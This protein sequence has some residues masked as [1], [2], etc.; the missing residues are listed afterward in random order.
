MAVCAIVRAVFADRSL[1]A[2]SCALAGVTTAQAKPMP[3]RRYNTTHMLKSSL[4]LLA[5]ALGG[6][7]PSES[8]AH[9]GPFVRFSIAGFPVRA[10]DVVSAASR[11]AGP[12]HRRG[13]RVAQ[14]N[15]PPAPR[16]RRDWRDRDR[17]R[18]LQLWAHRAAA[19]VPR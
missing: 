12:F 15:G 11:P 7:Q 19:G 14:R 6:G 3:A 2:R 16:P 4:R 9:F 1:R 13:D 17:N 18:R 10:R 5:T 8:L